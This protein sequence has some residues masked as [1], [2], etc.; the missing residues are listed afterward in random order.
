MIEGRLRAVFDVFRHH[1]VRCLLMGGQACVLYGAAEFSKDIDFA[2]FS[3]SENLEKAGEAMRTLQAEVIAVPPFD[4]ALLAL[5][6]AVHFRCHA[7]GV[8]GLRVDLMSKL[9]GVD[10]FEELW[11]RRFRVDDDR[12]EAIYLMAVEDL[13]IAKKTQRDKDWPMI[14][15]LMEVRYLAAGANPSPD[16]VAFWLRELRTPELLI[17][18]ARRYPGEV[19]ELIDKRPLLKHAVA[20]DAEVLERALIDE[21][22]AE[23][24]RDRKYWAP[25]KERLEELRRG[26]G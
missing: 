26:R 17:E 24:E 5:G 20:G 22:L 19:E 23:K 21:M 18:V 10:D 8:E 4:Q 14:Q 7:A 6:L 11:R 16:E 15:R 2:I 25:L 9:R 13:V 3:G 1:D 12:G